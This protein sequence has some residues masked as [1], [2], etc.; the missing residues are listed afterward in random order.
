MVNC[1]LNYGY[2]LLEAECLR[3]HNSVGLDAHDGFLHEMQIGKY[4]L[5]YDMQELFRFVV[6]LAVSTL[7]RGKQ[8]D[9]DLV[10]PGYSINRPDADDIRNKILG[11]PYSEW[12][13]RGLSKNG[14]HYMKKNA[15]SYKPFTLNKHVRKRLDQW[16]IE[17][18]SI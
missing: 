6:D 11:I 2:S 9:L 16:E 18:K 5:A 14:L 8:K 3:A 12:K 13:K 1:M 7:S 4:S 10:N 15:E 17:M